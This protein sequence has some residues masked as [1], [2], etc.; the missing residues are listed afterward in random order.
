MNITLRRRIYI[1]QCIM[2]FNKRDH[3]TSV[4][5]T[6]LDASLTPLIILA[7]SLQIL[8]MI[9]TKRNKFTTSQILFFILCLSDLSLGMIQLPLLVYFTW[10]P[11]PLTC[12]EIQVRAFWLV[13][14]M[15]L[16]GLNIFMISVDRFL[17]L[18][19]NKFYDKI[20]TNRNLVVVII[21]E[22]I[23][24]GVWALLYTL[25]SGGIKIKPLA[26]YFIALS[27]YEIVVL[28]SA[29]VLNIKLVRNIEIKRRTSSIRRKRDTN[30]TKTIA[31]IVV[32][33]VIAYTPTIVCA[34]VAAYIFLYSKD[35]KLMLDIADVLTWSLIAMQVNAILNS[36]IYLL[37]NTAI[38]RYYKCLFKGT[39]TGR[40]FHEH[41]S[42]TRSTATIREN[43]HAVDSNSVKQLRT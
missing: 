4:I 15:A 35:L 1:P 7:N 2:M 42:S 19:F 12:L 34:N 26:Y 21:F 14:P 13:F 25:I 43:I 31:I 41:G 22:L 30:L 18:G 33:L 5:S 37:R 23:I 24:S 11:D 20:K 17:L 39:T 16:S 32:T 29:V 8:G 38:K 9:K 28:S 10:K 6:A 40:Q 36:T 27:I 3:E